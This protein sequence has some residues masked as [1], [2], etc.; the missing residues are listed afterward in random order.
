LQELGESPFPAPG[1]VP[2]AALLLCDQ[3]ASS[4]V[5][6]SLEHGP[7]LGWRGLSESK[8]RQHL[9]ALASERSDG[10]GGWRR[11]LVENPQH[12]ADDIKALLTGLDLLRV[13]SSSDECMWWFSPAM[14]RWSLPPEP[15][16][17]DSMG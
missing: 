14:G 6:G 8:V 15:S 11:E 2:H 12:L 3:A 16:I 13:Y 10:R 1:T 7:G 17:S 9:E 5:S 4:G